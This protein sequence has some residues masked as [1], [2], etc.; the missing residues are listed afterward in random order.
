LFM[1]WIGMNEAIVMMGYCMRDEL[2][3]LE[4]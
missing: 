3:F 4:D 1:Q 2:S